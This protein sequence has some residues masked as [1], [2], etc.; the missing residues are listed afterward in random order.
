MSI[1]PLSNELAE[2]ARL[3]LYEEPNR[4]SNDIQHIK[5]WLAKQPH[6]RART[7]KLK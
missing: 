6:L 2:I 4:V 7:G 3:E 5:D 1:R